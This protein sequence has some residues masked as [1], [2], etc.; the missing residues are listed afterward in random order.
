MLGTIESDARFDAPIHTTLT[1]R[2]FELFGVLSVAIGS[3]VPL[4]QYRNFSLL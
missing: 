3:D 4:V 2:K 1:E